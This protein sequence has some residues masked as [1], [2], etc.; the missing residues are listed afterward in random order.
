MLYRHE[1]TEK[2]R[3]IIFQFNYELHFKRKGS[4]T[5]KDPVPIEGKWQA[6]DFRPALE[7]SLAFK[8]FD[9]DDSVSS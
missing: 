8:D 1:L 2:R 3:K 7:R 4:T 9:N 6:I 5:Q